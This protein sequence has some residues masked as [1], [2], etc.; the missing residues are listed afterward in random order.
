MKKYKHK[1]NIRERALDFGVE[2][3]KLVDIIPKTPAGYIIARQLIKAAT[4]IGANIEEAQ[5]SPTRKDF[6]NKLNISLKEA[7]ESKYW[8]KLLQKSK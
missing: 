8:L 1:I 3:I 6:V 7:R 4:S 2:I 5:S